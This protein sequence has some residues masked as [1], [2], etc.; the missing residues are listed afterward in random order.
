MNVQFKFVQGVCM[1]YSVWCVFIFI[2]TNVLYKALKNP[3]VLQSQLFI[4]NFTKNGCSR[5]GFRWSSS[6][7][8]C[9]DSFKCTKLD[10]VITIFLFL[11][12]MQDQ[13]SGWK[14]PQEFSSPS[15]L[16]LKAVSWGKR[17]SL[18]PVWTSLFQF[19]SI[20]SHPPSMHHGEAQCLHRDVTDWED[21]IWNLFT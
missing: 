4:R 12:H 20:V 1:F 14:G 19:M 8:C 13:D 17:S 16:P 15:N 11:L 5:F 7:Y 10:L 9:I 21:H 18:S 6:S 2:K 3:Q